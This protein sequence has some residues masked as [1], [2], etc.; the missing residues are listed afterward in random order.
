MA[1][2]QH[3]HGEPVTACDPCDQNFIRP[4]M[5]QVPPVSTFPDRMGKRKPPKW[6]FFQLFNLKMSVNRPTDAQ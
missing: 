1:S 3:L 6:P 4:A 5:G 2:E